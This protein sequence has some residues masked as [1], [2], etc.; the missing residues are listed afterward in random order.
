MKRDLVIF[1]IT[2]YA[3]QM[4]HYFSSSPD[5]RVVA[6]TADAQYITEPSFCGLPVLPFETLTATAPPDRFDLYI[7]I[8][9]NGVNEGRRSKYVEAKAKGYTL[10]SYVHAS[11]VVAS[12]VS[13]GDNTFIGELTVIKPFATLGCDLQ[14]G[15]QVH[16]GHDAVVRDHAFLAASCKLLGAVDIGEC[17]FIGANA[18]VRD[19]VTVGARCVVGAG[20]VILSDCEP[21]GVYRATAAVRGTHG[22]QSLRRI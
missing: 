3:K 6:F 16:V 22:S 9:Y 12:G 13:I 14:M 5:H 20:A 19:H 18:V 4:H 11:A 17:C 15:A 2:A 7:A 10:A 1:G 21:E 8:G